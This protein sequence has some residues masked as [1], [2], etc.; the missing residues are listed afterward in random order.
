MSKA[1]LVMDMPKSCNE[2]MLQE[3]DTI[4]CC[5]INDNEKEKYVSFD[6]KNER[7]KLCPLKEVP[8]EIDLDDIDEYDDDQY[9]FAKG[10]NA[11]IGEILNGGD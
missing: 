2:C 11:C 9:N 6:S 3:Y 1:I 7:H 5:C 10:Y 8:E 4:F